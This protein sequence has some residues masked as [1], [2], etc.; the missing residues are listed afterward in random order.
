MKTLI[1]I[2]AIS[3]GLFA[4]GSTEKETSSLESQKK[5]NHILV[6]FDKTQS[7]NLDDAFVRNKYQSALKSLIKQNI[8]SEGDI[9]EIYYIHEN[10]TKAKVLSL[11]VRTEKENSEGLNAT[12]LEAAQTN[13][14]MSIGKEQSMILDLAT[15]K[16]LEKN[17]GASNLETNISGSIQ[18]LSEALNDNAVVKAFYFSDMVESLKNGRDFHKTAPISHDQAQEWAKADAEKYTLYSL[19]NAQISII[20]PFSPNSS[21]KENNPN[22]TDYWKTYFDSLGALKVDEL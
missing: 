20:L 12:D 14:E 5:S 17:T 19:T 22:I 10:T 18:L 16:M 9:F 2:F 11:S 6:F 4:C 13:Y 8:Q 15:Q 1:F 7:V 3:F 21:T